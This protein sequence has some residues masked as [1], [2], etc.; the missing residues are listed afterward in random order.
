M[1]IWEEPVEFE[2]DKGNIEKNWNKHKVSFK[3]AEQPFVNNEK[4]IFPDENHSSSENRLAL[5]GITDK[6]RKLSIVFT[7]RS[8][9]VRIIMA[10]DM[11][12]KERRDYEKLKENS[13]IQK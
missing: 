2:W 6:G 10:R 1:K 3:E 9:K 5:F 4:F 8:G 12:K 7:I 11:S 13:K